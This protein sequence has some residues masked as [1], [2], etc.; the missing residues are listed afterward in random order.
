[1]DYS[2]ESQQDQLAKLRNG[3][4]IFYQL[5]SE[6]AE[7]HDKK[8]HDY[9][10]NS[11][12]F[13]NYEFAGILTSMFSHSPIDAGFVGRLGE[14]IFRLSVLEAGQKIPKNESIA[15]T[16]RDIAV[17]ATLW[18][19][20]RKERGLAKERKDSTDRLYKATRQETINYSVGERYPGPPNALGCDE[21][22]IYKAP[23]QEGL[24]NQADMKEAAAEQLSPAAASISSKDQS[25]EAL[26]NIINN[27]SNLSSEDLDQS[28]KYLSACRQAR[29]C[30]PLRNR[31]TK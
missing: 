15:D 3:S 19:A 2:T 29:E 5:L 12:P 23:S 30:L 20:A 26:C 4:P 1:M 10:S 18:M 24:Y 21:R 11:N 14:K 9:A 25:I 8:S 7:T 22:G 16:E 17:I 13:G 31:P 6:M 28:I 27:E